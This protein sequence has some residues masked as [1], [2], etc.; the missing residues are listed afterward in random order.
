M[1]RWILVC[2]SLSTSAV[3]LVW[4]VTPELDPGPPASVPASPGTA[5]DVG[6]ARPPAP[7]EAS[8]QPWPPSVEAPAAPQ[9]QARGPVVIPGAILVVAR[10]QE[11]P[12]EKEGRLLFIGT[13]VQPGEV[14]PPDRQ[15]DDQAVLG[16][17][18]VPV[19]DGE[20]VADGDK[21]HVDGKVA[22]YRRVRQTDPLEPGKVILVRQV[23]RVRRLREGD[24]VTRGQ[25]L[26]LVD[27][28]KMLDDVAGRLVKLKGAEADR[29]AAQKKAAEYEA[30][31][32]R[33]V[34]L[35]QLTS[36]S[37]SP[38]EVAAALLQRDTFAQEE[39]ARAAKVEEC[40]HDLRAGFTDLRRLEIRAAI[41]GTIS[42]I[43]KNG[44][45]DAVKPLEAILQIQNPRRL[46]VEGLL[47]VQE[48]LQLRQGACPCWSSPAV[49][50]ARA[51]S[52]AAT[53]A[54]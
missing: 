13:D 41:D 48:A 25:L 15:S 46:R 20:T 4:V 52:W 19:A 17:L 12:S 54:W 47:D 40:Q 51:W 7:P 10:Q 36:G 5:R 9:R 50:K 31:Y 53:W 30:R 23:R 37:V 49:R 27:P 3:G 22:V 16:V 14:V 44:G 38:E 1:T 24:R 26:A 35:Y 6:A 18:A 28:H 11:V 39:R 21:L 29:L 45:G 8:R 43:Y 33:Q 32:R 2:L 34:R 42:F